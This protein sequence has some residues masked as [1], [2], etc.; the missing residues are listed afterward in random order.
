[1]DTIR[2]PKEAVDR[3][4]AKA[5]RLHEIR[6]PELSAM[7]GENGAELIWH[8]FEQQFREQFEVLQ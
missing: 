6:E 2:L 7:F 4:L 1:M 5:R 8:R 3:A